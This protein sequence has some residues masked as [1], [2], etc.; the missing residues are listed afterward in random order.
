[1]NKINYGV[2]SWND[3]DDE[4]VAELSWAEQSVG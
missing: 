1:M 3:Y 4:R 2:I